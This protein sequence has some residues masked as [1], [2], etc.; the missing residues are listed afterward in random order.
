M[1][2]RISMRVRLLGRVPDPEHKYRDEYTQEAEVELTGDNPDAVKA[3]VEAK[4]AE[5]RA[6]FC[7]RLKQLG[8]AEYPAA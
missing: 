7:Q 5:V 4:A 8:G 6:E 2:C 3:A 1:S